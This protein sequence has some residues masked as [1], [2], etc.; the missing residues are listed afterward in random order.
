M[1]NLEEQVLKLQIVFAKHPILSDIKYEIQKTEGKRIKNGKGYLKKPIT[2]YKR[3]TSKSNLYL[4]IEDRLFH[5]ETLAL[6]YKVQTKEVKEN[7]LR[8]ILEGITV[9]ETAIETIIIIT[10]RGTYYINDVYE[11][12]GSEKLI[13]NFKDL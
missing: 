4:R 2:T 13:K 9:S 3:L 12:V 5:S 11:I 8:Y 10:K 6:L 7:L 1:D